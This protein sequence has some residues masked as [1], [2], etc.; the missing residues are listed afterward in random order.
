M[1]QLKV[2]QVPLVEALI[3]VLLL[4]RLALVDKSLSKAGKVLVAKED[5]SLSL[6]VPVCR[7]LLSEG[8]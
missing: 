2:D 5:P 1:Y 8:R 4:D 6:E 3:S 7:L